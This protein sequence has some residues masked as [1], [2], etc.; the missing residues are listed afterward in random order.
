MRKMFLSVIGLVLIAAGMVSCAEKAFA[1][2]SGGSPTSTSTSYI[3]QLYTSFEALG[4]G[5]DTASPDW[6][7]YWNRIK[8]AGSWTPTGDAVAADVASGKTFF[9]SSRT[10]LTGTAAGG[11]YGLPR[12]GYITKEAEGDD[13]TYHAGKPTYPADQYTATPGKSNSVTDNGTGLIWIK[14]HAAIGTVGG[15]NFSST[16]SWNNALL[17]VAAL[18]A[19]NGGAGYDGSNQWR[20]PNLKELQSLVDYGRF[21]PSI[22]PIFTSQSDY[23]WSGTT[24]AGSTV[25][26]WP[27]D[28][29]RG[30]VSHVYKDVGPGYVRPVRTGE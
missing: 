20:L 7:A 12:T 18:N 4:Y 24:L 1:E 23:Y 27:V 15:Y 2:Q 6:G 16:M 5:S 13:G 22:D 19:S 29:Y 3:K 9:G 11:S 10:L 14:D 30:F 21:N 28:F 8:T 25:V 26:A 17:A